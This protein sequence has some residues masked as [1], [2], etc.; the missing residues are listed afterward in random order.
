MNVGLFRFKLFSQISEQNGGHGRSL[1]HV[2]VRRRD[3]PRARSV[4]R[5]MVLGLRLRHGRRPGHRGQH[6]GPLL[7]RKKC[8]SAHKHSQVFVSCEIEKI[9]GSNL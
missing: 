4:Q 1:V 6:H 8:F 5:G 9:A 2:V 3:R 7:H